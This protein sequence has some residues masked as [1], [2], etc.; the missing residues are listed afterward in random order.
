MQADDGP[1]VPKCTR[2]YEAIIYRETEANFVAVEQLE[3]HCQRLPIHIIFG[4]DD[5]LV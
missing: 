3:A 1:V 5:V 2:Q 4:E